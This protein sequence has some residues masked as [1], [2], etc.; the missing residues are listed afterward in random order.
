[1]DILVVIT[2]TLAAN[3]I[4]AAFLYG[5]LR[6]HRNQ[7]DSAGLWMIIVAAGAALLTA[8]AVP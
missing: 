4:T 6:V 7:R 2:G 1:M 5:L 8:V 3:L